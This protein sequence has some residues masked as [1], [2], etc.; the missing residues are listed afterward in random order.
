M[1]I[2]I[3]YDGSADAKAAVRFA[4]E[5]LDGE[6]ATVLTVW[7]GFSE[8]VSRAASGMATASL[9]FEEIDRTREHEAHDIAQEGTGHARVA[10]LPASSKTARR[11]ASIAATI[12]EQANELGAD[13]IV[14]GSR[15]LIGARALVQ[16]SVSRAVLA[17][18]DCPVLVVPTAELAMRRSG[19]RPRRH[20]PVDAD[21]F[22]ARL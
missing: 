2:L 10:G 14:M 16:G 9:E 3:A 8:V 20:S 7:E 12:V 18:A 21:F 11:G 4:G 17:H 19:G 13:V 22:S 6:T 15:G 5:L 1:K